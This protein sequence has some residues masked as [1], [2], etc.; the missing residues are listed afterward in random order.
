M[1]KPPISYSISLKC[2]YS[3]IMFHHDIMRHLQLS[4]D[5]MICLS[6]MNFLLFTVFFGWFWV[7]T[8]KGASC[9]SPKEFYRGAS[10][11][12]LW[13]LQQTDRFEDQWRSMKI[14]KCPARNLP[15]LKSTCH[16]QFRWSPFFRRFFATFEIIKQLTIWKQI[17]QAKIQSLHSW[18]VGLR[19]WG[20]HRSGYSPATVTHD[21]ERCQAGYEILNL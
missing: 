16:S 9:I 14:K 1:F 4:V 12:L 3:F 7:W 13:S 18:S 19:C 15:H 6:G 8:C 5:V 11:H 2:I 20:N 10:V 21:V 17:R